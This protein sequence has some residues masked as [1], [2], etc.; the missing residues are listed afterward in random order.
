MAK[1]ALFRRLLGSVGAERANLKT[2]GRK[3]EMTP[4]VIGQRMTIGRGLCILGLGLCFLMT[5]V[6]RADAGS[7]DFAA[8]AYLWAECFKAGK[9][10]LHVQGWERSTRRSS[11]TMGT[12]AG[13]DVWCLIYP[14]KWPYGEPPGA[15]YRELWSS[16]GTEANP[17]GV[18]IWIQVGKQQRVLCTGLAKFVHDAPLQPEWFASPVCN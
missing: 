15:T 13:A 7:I 18:P 8:R 3:R 16:G 12:D 2:C 17:R 9:D 1:S 4:F 11:G 10:Y 14:A 5:P 6:P